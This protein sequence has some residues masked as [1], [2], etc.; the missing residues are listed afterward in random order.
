MR[1]SFLLLSAAVLLSGCYSIAQRV[2]T[3]SGSASAL[4][5]VTK[6]ER[7]DQSALRGRFGLVP[8]ENTKRTVER[9][10]EFQSKLNSNPLGIFGG[11]KPLGD[12]NDPRYYVE[13]VTNTVKRHVRSLA[14]FDDVNQGKG[15]VDY[16]IFLDTFCDE[17]GWTTDATCEQSLEVFD[18]ALTAR[19]L[20]MRT[21]AYQKSRDGGVMALVMAR[22]ELLKKF[23]QQFDEQM[24][25]VGSRR[26]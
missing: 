26:P 12:L 21:T 10:Q 25:G 9:F 3:Y 7:L 16:I 22:E 5:T 15:R 11:L 20:T 14:V 1:L 4:K 23:A 24:A 8:S 2:D 18:A 6:Q 19:Y 17:S 13:S